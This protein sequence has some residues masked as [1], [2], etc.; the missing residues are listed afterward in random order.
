MQVRSPARTHRTQWHI[1]VWAAVAEYFRFGVAVLNSG[2]AWGW[3]A[4]TRKD[5]VVAR[6]PNAPASSEFINV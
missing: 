6:L 2:A 5:Q 1:P 3:G 4:L